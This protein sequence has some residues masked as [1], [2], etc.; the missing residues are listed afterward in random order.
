MGEI[1][2]GTKSI[3]RRNF[4]SKALLWCAA[5][6]VGSVLNACTKSTIDPDT[7]QAT[8]TRTEVQRLTPKQRE[9]QNNIK[10][11][12]IVDGWTFINT[13]VSDGKNYKLKTDF[14]AS[15]VFLNDLAD[16][17]HT[18]SWVSPDDM[19]IYI[20]IDGASWDGSTGQY[21]S[22]P[23]RDFNPDS[24]LSTWNIFEQNTWDLAKTYW[25]WQPIRLDCSVYANKEII[26]AARGKPWFIHTDFYAKKIIDILLWK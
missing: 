10:T 3:D 16:E 14:K 23:Y 19:T 24:F 21:F 6:A 8:D 18:K 7:K 13:V 9:V 22:V 15:P 5:V 17:V 1:N 12:Q 4:L 11:T 2:K 25:H 26:D 20:G